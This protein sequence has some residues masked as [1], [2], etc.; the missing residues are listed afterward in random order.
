MTN[1]RRSVLQITPLIE[2]AG[3]FK[4]EVRDVPLELVPVISRNN[5]GDLVVK[6]IV[7][8]DAEIEVVFAGRR[9]RE[10]AGLVAQLKKLRVQGVR[11]AMNGHEA[12]NNIRRLRLPVQVRGTWRLR[13]DRDASGWEVKSYQLL[14]A[15]WAFADAD[16]YTVL[17][18]WPPGRQIA[19]P[20][21]RR[22]GPTGRGT[23]C[24]GGADRLGLLRTGLHHTN[25]PPEAGRRAQR[26]EACQGRRRAGGPQPVFLISTECG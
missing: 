7:Q 25:A 22:A 2:D 17:C 21:P 19:G 15:Q 9:M 16:G 20:R 3:L 13:F 14:A 26:D 24:A 10:A 6:G 1:R 18:G 8:P 5:R 11:T 23:G 4:R 12:M